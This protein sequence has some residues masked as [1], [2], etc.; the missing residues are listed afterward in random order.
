MNSHFSY[1]AENFNTL[2]LVTQKMAHIYVDDQFSVFYL[3]G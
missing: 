1:C 3:A 2:S